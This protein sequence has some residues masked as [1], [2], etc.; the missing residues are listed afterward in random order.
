MYG[1]AVQSDWYLEIYFKTE[2]TPMIKVQVSKHYWF[3]V[4]TESYVSL[5]HAKK[6]RRDRY[7]IISWLMAHGKGEIQQGASLDLEIVK[8]TRLRQ[9]FMHG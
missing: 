1:S 2:R 5:T 3:T 4:K 6:E 8:S 7:W 9:S